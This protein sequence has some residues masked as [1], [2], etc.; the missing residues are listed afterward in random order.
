MQ[1]VDQETNILLAVL[2]FESTEL[3]TA[4]RDGV[5]EVSGDYGCRLGPHALQE[6]RK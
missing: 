4:L 2:L 1:P 6:A 5:L 3:V